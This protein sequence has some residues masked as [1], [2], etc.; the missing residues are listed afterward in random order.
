MGKSLATVG[1]WAACAAA[2]IFSD[3]P[4]MGMCFIAAGLGTMFMWG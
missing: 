2:V 1:M 3:N 4:Y